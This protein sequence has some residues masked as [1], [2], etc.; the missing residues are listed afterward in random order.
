M[1]DFEEFEKKAA[2]Q[3]SD[4]WT[5]LREAFE[6]DPVEKRIAEAAA[7]LR[8]LP[9]EARLVLSEALCGT[10]PGDTLAEFL[11]AL[12]PGEYLRLPA[13]LNSLLEDIQFDLLGDYGLELVRTGI[14]DDLKEAGVR[15]R[16]FYFLRSD[17]RGDAAGAAA[18]KLKASAVYRLPDTKIVS[19][20]SRPF[21]SPEEVAEALEIFADPGNWDE[22]DFLG[23]G[24][25]D[26]LMGFAGTEAWTPRN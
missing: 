12:D 6:K 18:A 20:E 17:W 14:S 25:L 10:E 2:A 8:L 11:P 24:K 7:G 1:I 22:F 4:E 5:R 13:A 16:F 15:T 23:G 19:V 21:R 3:L 26:A 9:E